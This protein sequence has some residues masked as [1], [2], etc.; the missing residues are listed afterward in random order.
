MFFRQ[1]FTI[2]LAII[3][4]LISMIIFLKHLAKFVNVFAIE[5][6]HV[7][8]SY[9]YTFIKLFFIIFVVAFPF[10]FDCVLF[11]CNILKIWLTFDTFTS[12]LVRLSATLDHEFVRNLT[13]SINLF[14]IILFKF[15]LDW[16]WKSYVLFCFLLSIQTALQILL[17]TL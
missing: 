3:H 14:F 2:S 1:C 17:L 13:L 5:P 16:Y 6:V 11:D 10:K 4:L 15:F 12:T 7:F 9:C 8:K